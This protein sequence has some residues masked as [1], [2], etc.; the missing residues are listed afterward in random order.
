MRKARSAV[1][2]V[3]TMS[4]ACRTPPPVRSRTAET[5]SVVVELTTSV[6]PKARARRNRTSWMST[7]TMREA[8]ARPAAPIVLSPTPPVPITATVS[9]SR[10]RAALR[11]DPAPV[12]TAQPSRAAGAGG[13]R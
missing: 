1:A 10:T 12:S 7:A 3:P 5:A 6:A 13:K 4:K 2:A 9:P 8:P 11:T